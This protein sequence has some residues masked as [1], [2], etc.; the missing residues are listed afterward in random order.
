MKV[1]C[2]LGVLTYGIYPLLIYLSQ[3]TLRKNEKDLLFFFPFSILPTKNCVH[4]H[5]K[6]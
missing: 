1:D 5:I 3:H 4:K 6:E 2:L